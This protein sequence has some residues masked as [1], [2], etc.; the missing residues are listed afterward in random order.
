LI[1]IQE[2]W[3]R[4]ELVEKALE[5]ALTHVKKAQLSPEVIRCIWEGGSGDQRLDQVDQQVERD[6]LA[7]RMI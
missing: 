6:S 7:E 3:K 1:Q 5:K 4:P 2:N